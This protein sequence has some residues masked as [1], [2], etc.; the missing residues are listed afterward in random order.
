MLQS[1][2]CPT[3]HDDMGLGA[4]LAQQLECAHAI[5]H[6]GRTGDA[7]NE[8]LGRSHLSII[9]N[10][11]RPALGTSCASKSTLRILPPSANRTIVP[12]TGRS[13]A[14]VRMGVYGWKGSRT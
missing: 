13:A 11:K 10:Q 8:P 6:A 2:Y 14:V 12:M 3:A 1:P 4:G 5:N 7:D 9:S